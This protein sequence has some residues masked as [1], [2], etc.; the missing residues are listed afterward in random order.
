MKLNPYLSPCT[1]LNSKWMKDIGIRTET[2]HLI[3]DKVSPNLH[4][5]GLGSDLLNKTPK[6]QEIKARINKWDGFKLKSFFSANET[7]M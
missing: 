5:V 6:A 1:K 7:I 2:L 3:E 4:H